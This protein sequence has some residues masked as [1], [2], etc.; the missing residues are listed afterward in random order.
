MKLV[1]TPTNTN[2]PLELDLSEFS[3]ETLEKSKRDT[4]LADEDVE[5]TFAGSKLKSQQPKHQQMPKKSPADLAAERSD[6]MN[7]VSLSKK[8]DFDHPNLYFCTFFRH[9]KN[10]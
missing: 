5:L 1:D 8:V 9:C 3:G 2:Y 7:N 4:E 6:R 10:S